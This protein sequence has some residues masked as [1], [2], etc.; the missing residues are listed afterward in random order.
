MTV[1]SAQSITQWVLEMKQSRR[2]LKLQ[3]KDAQC[4]TQRKDAQCGT[5]R[6]DAPIRTQRKDAHCRTWRLRAKQLSNSCNPIL[7]SNSLSDPP[8]FFWY[9]PDFS[10]PHNKKNNHKEERV[11]NKKM[12]A[13]WVY[14]IHIK[15]LPGRMEDSKFGKDWIGFLID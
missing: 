9:L 6:K 15:S 3:R 1:H 4:R 5:Q 2:E 13:N 11:K 10:L 14:F 12:K 7:L 8:I